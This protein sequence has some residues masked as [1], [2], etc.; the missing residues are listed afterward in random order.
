MGVFGNPRCSDPASRM[1]LM[2]RRVLPVCG[3]MC[4][5]C[6]ALRARSRQPVKRYNM[7]LADI[8]PK[9]QVRIYGAKLLK[10]KGG[11]ER[12]WISDLGLLVK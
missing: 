9:A 7:L 3:S 6:P 2:S 11:R 12:A 4:V 5:C 10:C 8:Y 1:G